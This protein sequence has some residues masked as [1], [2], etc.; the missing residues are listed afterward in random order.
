VGRFY[1][2]LRAARWRAERFL[3]LLAA[4]GSGCA[5]K[6]SPSR[7]NQSISPRKRTGWW[8]GCIRSGRWLRTQV[9]CSP[10]ARFSP[11]LTGDVR[12]RDAALTVPW[13]TLIVQVPVL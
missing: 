13:P 8:P 12:F 7:K 1:D 6:T 9:R 2:G 5:L 11:R 10:C 4:R 3:G